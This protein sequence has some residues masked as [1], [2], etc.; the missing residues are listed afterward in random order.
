MPETDAQSELDDLLRR[1]AATQ[2]LAME[3]ALAGVNVTPAQYAVLK[4]SP[5]R[6][7]SATRRSRGSS[8]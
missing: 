7:A 5:R 6:P 2:R 8:G 3:R 4:S 1:A